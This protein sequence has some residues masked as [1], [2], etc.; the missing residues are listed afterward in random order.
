ME[1]LLNHLYQ[2]FPV[3]GV[4]SGGGGGLVSILSGMFSSSPLSS[5]LPIEVLLPSPSPPSLSPLPGLL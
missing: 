2:L 5:Q 4:L 1:I 3:V